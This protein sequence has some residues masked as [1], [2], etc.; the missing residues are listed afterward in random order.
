MGSRMRVAAAACLVTSGLFAGGASGAVA[1]AEPAGGGDPT[2]TGS[3]GR[4]GDDPVTQPR[5]TSPRGVGAVTGTRSGSVGPRSAAPP[6]RTTGP[7]DAVSAGPTDI[8]G[9]GSSKL[10]T[11]ES[12][13]DGVASGDGAG[14]PDP[15]ADRSDVQDDPDDDPGEPGD[16]DDPDD[17]DECGWG[18][19]PLP[20]DVAP[21][22]PNG[23]D[24]YGGGISSSVQPPVRRP[25][26][27]PGTAIP[28]RELLPESSVPS[29]V[30]DLVGPPPAIVLPPVAPG[31]AGSVGSSE[32]T[33]AAPETPRPPAPGRLMPA[34]RPAPPRTGDGRVAAASS[35]RA[36]YGE[37]LR[38]ADLPQVIVVAVPGATGI[39]LLTGAGGLIGY[40]QARAGLVVRAR[41]MGRFSS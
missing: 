35:Y 25:M 19:W 8:D 22:A 5:R 2:S 12:G 18:W 13:V 27:P 40:R 7:A 1:L 31:I 36:G 3:P 10:D 38:T 41:R 26:V 23:G 14:E 33:T 16:T 21:S 15:V 34:E 29:A 11:P 39:M 20:P 32:P 37:Y 17:E 4:A 30:P 24:G 9:A 6:A 28:P